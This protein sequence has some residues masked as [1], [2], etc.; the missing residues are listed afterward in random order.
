MPAAAHNTR[1][2]PSSKSCWVTVSGVVSAGEYSDSGWAALVDEGGQLAV[3]EIIQA[4]THQA[5]TLGGDILSERSE[6]E[7]V[8]KPVLD[9]RRV[10]G[11]DIHQVI[12][13]QCA[14]VASNCFIEKV[15]VQAGRRE[16]IR[17]TDR[18][19]HTNL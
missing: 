11:C 12:S 7:L 6:I 18:H 4:A 13:A 8:L 10:R 14:R 9:G 17:Q 19:G 16:K 3:V 5:E 2:K 1:L 15:L